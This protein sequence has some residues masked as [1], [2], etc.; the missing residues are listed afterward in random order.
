MRPGSWVLGPAKSPT[1]QVQLFGYA[2]CLLLPIPRISESFDTVLVFLMMKFQI[3]YHGIL[4]SQQK[5][6]QHK[7]KADDYHKLM[8]LDILQKQDKMM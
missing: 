6:G 3:S 7:N 4:K 5:H 2:V 1:S 8:I